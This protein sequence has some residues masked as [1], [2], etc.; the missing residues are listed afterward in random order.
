MLRILTFGGLTV[1]SSE[2]PG[3]ALQVRLQ[4]L[5]LLARLAVAGERGVS[6]EKLV[7][8]FWPETDERNALH[9]LSQALHRLKNELGTESPVL[10]TRILRLDPEL[11]STDVAD[12]EMADRAGNAECAVALYAGP[13]LDGIFVSGAPEFERWAEEERR[14]LADRHAGALRRLA[15][16][17]ASRGEHDAASQWW[18]RLLATDPLDGRVAFELIRSLASA[19]DEGSAIREAQRHQA[20]VRTELH[21]EPDRRI[22]DLIASLDHRGS[23]PA[24]PAISPQERHELLTLTADQ[25]CARARQSF[26][27]ITREAMAGGI[28]YAERAIQLSPEHAQAHVTAGWLHLFLSQGV[29]PH[30]HRA[31]GRAHALR[32]A[33]LDPGL[34]DAPLALAWASQLDHQFDDAERYA[35]QGIALDPEYPFAHFVLGWAM[36]NYGLRSGHRSKCEE[37]VAALGASLRKFQRD[38]HS[39]FGLASMYTCAGQYAA[40]QVLLERAAELEVAPAGE[41]P[42]IGALTLL[43]L[44]H[45]RREELADAH[46]A[47]AAATRYA[48]APQIYAPYVNALTDCAMGDL[49][50]FAGRYDEAVAYYGR[51]RRMVDELPYLIGAGYLAIRLET[52]LA[53]CYRP[54]RM[55][56]EE[57]RHGRCAD[58]LTSSREGYSFNWCWGTSEGE[59]HYD[60][61]VLH[62]MFGDRR[63]MIASLEEAMHFGWRETGLLAIEP[64][65][66]PFA[67]DPAVA[68]LRRAA[69]AISPLP[70]D[71][72]IVHLPR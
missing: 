52:R 35:R 20:L 16:A 53:G 37:S 4:G 42:A 3:R 48:S 43:G 72:D 7:G 5:A 55:R 71:E 49:E 12:F 21:R 60:W 26:F 46:R 39:L 10:G 36:L 34:P 66:A 24:A 11:V 33:S 1:E 13:F 27:T 56:P 54:L 25:L 41:I 50:R 6:R 18:R 70:V 40:A 67:G 19:G 65:F 23:R 15:A 2:R 17:A 9:S 61:A 47:L 58:R 62:A 44:L 22:S 28:R 38:P 29:E 63:S 57:E 32:A 30:E 64:A 14:R 59:M 45:M 31:K 69:E 8:Y 68:E 51:A